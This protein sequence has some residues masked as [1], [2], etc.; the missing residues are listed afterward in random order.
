MGW[1]G[2][3][4]LAC[5]VGSSISL[6][7]PS[8]TLQTRFRFDDFEV[9]DGK[10]TEQ[11]LRTVSASA[12]ISTIT[13]TAPQWIS[14][15]RVDGPSFGVNVRPAGFPGVG[16]FSG[17][18]VF[19]ASGYSP[20]RLPVVAEVFPSDNI[21]VSLTSIPIDVLDG[22]T[23]PAVNRLGVS[24]V[25]QLPRRN[26]SLIS[27]ASWMRVTPISGS[28]GGPIEASITIDSARVPEGE[29]NET[30]RVSAA[31]PITPK[32]VRVS[33]FIER[34]PPPPPVTLNDAAIPVLNAAS[35]RKEPLA[36]GSLVTLF[37]TD[38]LTILTPSEGQATAALPTRIDN[39]EWL[40]GGKPLQLIYW[41]PTQ[42][43]ALIPT[44]LP[45]A[46]PL[47]FQR[48]LHT[49]LNPRG[50]LITTR[51]L[52]KIRL[53]Q[54]A[55]GLFITGKRE[56]A[57]SLQALAFEDFCPGTPMFLRPAITD[58]AG[59]LITRSNPARL[60]KP[61]I[62]WGT[63]L[64]AAARNADGVMVFRQQPVVYISKVPPGEAAVFSPIT[65]LSTQMLFAGPAPTFP[66]LDQINFV[67]PSEQI[68]RS[69]FCGEDLA[70]EVRVW[71]GPQLPADEPVSNQGTI[72][73]LIRSG[74]APCVTR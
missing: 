22:Q 74:D 18:V 54:Q 4:A 2:R 39:Y 37:P 63:G 6:A 44:D 27:S 32:L 40:L 11:L 13:W 24:F 72:P 45:T 26:V 65:N 43:N 71:I 21:R 48:D 17:E 73:I 68:S 41:S 38:P 30:I 12:P 46:G 15:V 23:R 58:A 16:R 9:V 36:P 59:N 51:N 52:G 55:P 1:I 49:P 60:N 14:L 62:M 56:C 61:M 25:A 10:V 29:Y 28:M 57:I 3:A 19:T 67:I 35:A 70:I 64:G 8:M 50:E 53:S 69:V 42:I 34:T 31:A 47:D 20:A 66:G 7:Q 5:F 33:V